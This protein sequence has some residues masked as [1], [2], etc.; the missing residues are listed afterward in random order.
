[1][2]S[3]A[4]GVARSDLKSCLFYS[5]GSR[6]WPGR[7]EFGTTTVWKSSFSIPGEDS[8]LRCLNPERVSSVSNASLCFTARLSPATS[9]WSM[10]SCEP[11]SLLWKVKEEWRPLSSSDS[12]LPD[13]S[14]NATQLSALWSSPVDGKPAAAILASEIVVHLLMFSWFVP[15]SSTIGLF[16]QFLLKALTCSSVSTH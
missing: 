4:Q 6:W 9:C 10:R 2:C 1:M 16:M 12:C 15:L 14:V 13:G 11:D 3:C 7:L 8:L 5:Q